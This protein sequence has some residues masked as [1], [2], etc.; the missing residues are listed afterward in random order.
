L[1]TLFSITLDPRDKDRKRRL[2]TAL[3]SSSAWEYDAEDVEP[4]L[5]RARRYPAVSVVV[6]ARPDKI[7]A[8]DAWHDVLAVTGQELSDATRGA[9]GFIFIAKRSKNGYAFIV[10]ARNDAAMDALIAALPNCPLTP[11]VCKRL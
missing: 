9:D 5:N 11:G 10:S 7:G 3:H 6:I 1:N 4:F 8:I 2:R